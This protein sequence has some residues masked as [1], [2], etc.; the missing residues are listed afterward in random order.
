M[1]E[2]DHLTNMH[3]KGLLHL[4][5]GQFHRK[6]RGGIVPW[7]SAAARVCILSFYQDPVIRE[8]LIDSPGRY[9]LR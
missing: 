5:M 8:T 9:V 3:K 7:R 1:G 4:A 6:S 2:Q